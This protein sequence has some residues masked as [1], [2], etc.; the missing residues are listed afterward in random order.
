MIKRI[1]NHVITNPARKEIDAT[2][3]GKKS[4]YSQQVQGV[5]MVLDAFNYGISKNSQKSVIDN[6]KKVETGD[7]S[8]FTAHGLESISFLKDGT[9][10]LLKG[11]LRQGSIELLGATLN[12]AGAVYKTS[13]TQTPSEKKGVDPW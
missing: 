2:T 8:E 11:E 9:K 13:Y 10:N 12:A 3:Q 4:D 6:V 5:N 7:R 1:S